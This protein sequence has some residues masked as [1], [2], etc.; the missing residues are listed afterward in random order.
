MASPARQ[1]LGD[2]QPQKKLRGEHQPLMEFSAETQAFVAG[3]LHD[4]DG[5]L[6]M[7]QGGNID[8]TLVHD[9]A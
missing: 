1:V 6:S 8:F 3:Q 9:T 7:V 5:R 4:V 2:D